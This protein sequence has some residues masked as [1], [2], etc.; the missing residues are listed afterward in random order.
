MASVKGSLALSPAKRGGEDLDE[1]KGFRAKLL[2]LYQDTRFSDVK[3]FVGVNK[4]CFELHRAVITLQSGFFEAAC[5]D[6]FQEG[7]SG[8]IYIAEVPSEAF[9]VVVLWIYEGRYKFPDPFNRKLVES[10]F[11][12]ADYLLIQGLKK[13]ILKAME[14]FWKL[15]GIDEREDE[16]FQ[17]FETL[18][19]HSQLTDWK[20][21]REFATKITKMWY[22]RTENI[23]KL[24]RG[25]SAVALGL[26]VEIYENILRSAVCG[27][28][29]IEYLPPEDQDCMM[30]GDKCTGPIYVD[31]SES[32]ES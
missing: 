12:A 27:P 7:K 11:I 26:F 13:D 17:L 30:C 31:A 24:S 14:G 5:K 18:Y 29:R 2:K 15:P 8:E 3:V 25:G 32:K 20:D 9:E 4:R 22:V 1:N 16:A 21:L 28:C 6:C 19:K 23:L 10:V